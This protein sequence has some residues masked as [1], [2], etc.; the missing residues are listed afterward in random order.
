MM[1]E[2]EIDKE[3]TFALEMKIDGDV[4]ASAPPVMRFSIVTEDFTF[5]IPA[6]RVDNGIYEVSCP[7]LKGILKPGEYQAQ[8]EVF[9]EDKH[10]IPMSDTV[11]I[12]EEVKPVVKLAEKKPVKKVVEMSVAI[13]KVEAK[14]LM[15]AVTP[16]LV[17][18]DEIIT[19]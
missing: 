18:T 1:I 19:I 14:P 16:T 6:N 8:V 5:S 17:K 2:L 11:V 15:E 9:I 13:T 3:S 12:K 4:S 7:K 10:F